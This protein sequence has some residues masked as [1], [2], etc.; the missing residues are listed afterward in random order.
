METLAELE[1][2]TQPAHTAW[3][4]LENDVFVEPKKGIGESVHSLFLC[5]RTCF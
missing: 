3:Y 1:H 4:V 5:L 2:C